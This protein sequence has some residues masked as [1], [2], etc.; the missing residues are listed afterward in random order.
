MSQRA[1]FTVQYVLMHVFVMF[2][3]Q[4]MTPSAYS[5]SLAAVLCSLGAKY[6]PSICTL[7]QR[8]PGS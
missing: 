4:F 7:T 3:E 5:A 6:D 2:F 1:S 8:P